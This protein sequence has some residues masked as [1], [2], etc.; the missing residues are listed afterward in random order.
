M[1]GVIWK[2]G[3]VAYYTGVKRE[4][5]SLTSFNL[6]MKRI[7]TVGRAKERRE[8]C[9]KRKMKNEK[10]KQLMLNH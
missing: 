4:K 8:I 5:N 2:V 7:N 10:R 9:R 1:Q 3:R 6:M